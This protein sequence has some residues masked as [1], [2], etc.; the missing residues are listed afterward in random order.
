MLHSSEETPSFISL[1]KSS[2][3][4]ASAQLLPLA[5]TAS[6]PSFSF[7]DL[8]GNPLSELVLTDSVFRGEDPGRDASPHICVGGEF[9]KDL[10]SVPFQ[11]PA[12]ANLAR[13][14]ETSQTLGSLLFMRE[15]LSFWLGPT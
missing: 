6:L 8:Q 5:A 12:N 13:L 7:V 4:S 9:H 3:A 11:L 14:Q 10:N 2:R 15:T 1:A